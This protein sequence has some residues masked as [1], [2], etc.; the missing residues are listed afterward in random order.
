MKS[1]AGHILDRVPARWK[2]VVRV[3]PIVAVLAVGKLAIHLAEADFIEPTAL[4]RS[5]VAATMFFLGFLLAGTL[6]DYKERENDSPANSPQA[7]SPWPTNASSRARTRPA[8]SLQTPFSTS[9]ASPPQPTA[10]STGRNAHGHHGA[11]DRHERSLSR[12]GTAHAAELHR[13]HETG[14]EQHPQTN[15]AHRYDTRHS[16]RP[17]R[18]HD[19]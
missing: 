6:T 3:L 13:A 1:P 15:H 19:R 4:I 12:P 16:F 18:L 2:L 9:L 7:S 17:R 10:G 5:V 8:R 11:P 14:A